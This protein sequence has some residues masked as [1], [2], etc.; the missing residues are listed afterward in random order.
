MQLV[1]PGHTVLL[2]MRTS[3]AMFSYCSLLDAPDLCKYMRHTVYN[4]IM[5][6]MIHSIDSQ[7][8]G[9]DPKAGRRPVLSRSQIAGHILTGVH[10]CSM[11]AILTVI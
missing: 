7:L 8:V 11:V 1:G 10:Q 2:E 9:W 4:T 3:L 6:Y 5:L